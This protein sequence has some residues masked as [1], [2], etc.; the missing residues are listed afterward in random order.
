M[1]RR[2]RERAPRCTAGRGEADL[3][4][5]VKLFMFLQYSSEPSSKRHR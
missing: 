2:T 5:V 1:I 4:S 3:R